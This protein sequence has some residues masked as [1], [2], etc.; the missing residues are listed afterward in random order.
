MNPFT[1]IGDLI[2]S[3]PAY[4]QLTLA[5]HLRRPDANLQKFDEIAAN[6]PISLFAG[7]DA[8]SNIGFHLFGDDAGNKL[9]NLKID[10]YATSFGVVRVHV[11]IERDKPLGRE[12][13]VEAIKAGRFFIGFDAI[14]DTT[15]FRF[16]LSRGD[17][18][19]PMGGTLA[20]TQYPRLTLNVPPE[21]NA[22]PYRLGVPPNM[23]VKIY[24]NGELFP[25]DLVAAIYSKQA[26]LPG[27]YRVEV[28]RDDLGP[29][30]DKMP[31]ILSNPIYVR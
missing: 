23:S 15:G 14:G 9:I 17:E 29:P 13:L 26:F 25:L 8:H 19:I 1:A 27:T 24:R 31:W 30:F 28:Y 16:A 22:Q 21:I 4:P 6:R 5:T 7:T 10:P 12:S 2:W 20:P 11:L 3:Y 18:T